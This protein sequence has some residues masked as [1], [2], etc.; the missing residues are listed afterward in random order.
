MSKHELNH[1][2]L[3]S[4]ASNISED[5]VDNIKLIFKDYEITFLKSN[6][7]YNYI[8]LIKIKY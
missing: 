4:I 1:R 7:N 6:L 5:K 3:Q 8:C 2:V